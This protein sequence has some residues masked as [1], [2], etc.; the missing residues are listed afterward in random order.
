[1]LQGCQA[2]VQDG[3]G[4]GADEVAAPGGDLGCPFHVVESDGPV[5]LIE[6]VESR[7]HPVAQLDR[8]AAHGA[9]DGRVLA[10][11]VARDIDPSSEGQ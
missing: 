7:G 4:Q 10:F 11:R 6:G 1:V 9:R 2:A 8:H 5:S 3:F